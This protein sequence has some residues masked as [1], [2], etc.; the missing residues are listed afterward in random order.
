[1]TNLANP[2]QIYQ[3]VKSIN[4]VNDPSK[5]A[6]RQCCGYTLA[7]LLLIASIFTALTQIKFMNDTAVKTEKI[8]YAIYA[9]GYFVPSIFYFNI[10]RCPSFIAGKPPHSNFWPFYLSIVLKIVSL[11]FF[12]EKDLKIANV[13]IKVA[14][15]TICTFLMIFICGLNDESNS[16]CSF[17]KPWIYKT[18]M[19]PYNLAYP[20]QGQMVGGYPLQAQN[21]PQA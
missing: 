12:L 17:V 19:V 16:C 1:M 7:I 11:V 8:F 2:A 10:L 5:E 6:V 21:L 4:P 9:V 20:P 14:S 15:E 18:K 13:R 3:P